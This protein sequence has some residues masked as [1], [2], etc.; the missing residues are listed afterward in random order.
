MANPWRAWADFDFTDAW[1]YQWHCLSDNVV[2]VA[3]FVPGR[4]VSV[5]PLAMCEV[6]PIPARGAAPALAL[7]DADPGPH[8]WDSAEAG[9]DGFELPECDEDELAE[10]LRR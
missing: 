8:R 1:S 3:E 4:F 7:G 10:D 6:V 5:A 9:G 2:P